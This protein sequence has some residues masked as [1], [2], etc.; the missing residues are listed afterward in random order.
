MITDRSFEFLA[1]LL[2]APGPSGYEIV[3]A[4]VWREEAETF[5]DRSEADV[6][7]NSVAFLNP[8]GSPRVMLAGHIDEIGLIVTHVDDDGFLYFDGIGGWDSQ[9]LVGQRV[10]LLCQSGDIV[11]V[12]GKQPIHLLKT[13]EREKVSKLTDLWIDIGASTRDEALNRGVR[14]GDAGVIDTHLIR[15][16]E[17]LIASRAIDNRIG[18]YIVLEALRLLASEDP[19]MAAEV[20][21]VATTQEEIGYHGGGARTSAHRLDPAV[22]IVVDVTFASDA[23]H[24]EKNQTGEH[25]LGSG[26]V[27]TRGA[28]AHPVV[29]DGLVAAAD[30]AGIPF[31]IQAAA[32]QTMTD[33]DAIYLSRDGVATA[34]VSVPNRYMH[35]PNEIVSLE[36]LDSTARLI[37]EFV[38]GLERDAEFIHR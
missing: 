3:P 23:P 31:T 38:R 13:E 27:L 20:A 35:S 1:R 21:A 2:D 26:P 17:K 22:A 16:G 4:R 15:L 28:A 36:D 10:R 37:A 33:A 8:G 34:V 7:G 14:V 5:A 25:K 19:P 30:R 6:S 11:G 29:F 9:V 18:A 12:I 24:I 32:R